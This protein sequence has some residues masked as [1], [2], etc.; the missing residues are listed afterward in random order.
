M[1]TPL[2]MHNEVLA[3]GFGFHTYVI[4]GHRMGSW[5]TLLP[6]RQ[7][8]LCGAQQRCVLRDRAGSAC[9]LGDWAGMPAVWLAGSGSGR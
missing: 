5:Y 3:G 8:G 4:E 7:V 9:L 2:A 6:G 1:T